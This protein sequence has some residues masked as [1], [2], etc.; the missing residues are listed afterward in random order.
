[1][2]EGRVLSS[3]PHILFVSAFHAPFID[4]DLDVLSKD[5]AVTVCIGHGFRQIIDIATG[6]LRADVV[7]CWFTS[8]YAAIATLLAKFFG[9]K[10]VIVVGG[11]DVAGDKDLGYGIWLNPWKKQLIKFAL[12]NAHRVLVVD[13]SLKE[14]AIRRARY[15]GANIECVP[16]G[17]DSS[18]WIPAGKKQPIVLTV[19]IARDWVNVRRKG[20]DL[21]VDAAKK[22]PQTRFLVIGT[23]PALVAQFSPL[24]NI[25]FKSRI[26]RE[27]L[28]VHYQS[29]K[30]YCQPSRW[31]GLP[32]ALCEAMLCGCIPVATNV[33]GQPTAL[34]ESGILVTKG[35]V[36]ELVT[37]L[38]S[39]MGMSESA[40]LKGRERIATLFPK[41]RRESR[42][43]TL[44][45]ELVT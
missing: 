10:C 13:P 9:K 8:V 38:E 18:V 28:L 30:V 22:L 11:V 39:A 6:L 16:T 36:D 31:E 42:L 43:R 12:R 41:Q 26:P 14:E 7:F 20:L 15:D 29:A 32:N 33:F 23:D 5:F 44:I 17:Y 35:N 37:A 40:G 1:L 2:E 34:G 4:D 27:E 19:A 25:V 21:L 45:G 3:Q 24:D